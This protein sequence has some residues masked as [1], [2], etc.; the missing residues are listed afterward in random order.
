MRTNFSGLPLVSAKRTL[1]SITY[2]PDPINFATDLVLNETVLFE[3]DDFSATVD[4]GSLDISVT[5]GG[6]LTYNILTSTLGA[7]SNPCF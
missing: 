6:S 4:S 5:V 1:G 2:S 7:F 3:V